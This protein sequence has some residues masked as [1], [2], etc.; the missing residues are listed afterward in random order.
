MF[1]F[2]LVARAV[3]ESPPGV[4]V[5]VSGAPGPG[6]TAYCD[7]TGAGAVGASF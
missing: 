5:V 7:H 3:P 2:Y 4:R 6:I 1:G